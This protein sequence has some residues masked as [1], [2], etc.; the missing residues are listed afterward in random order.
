VSDL[1]AAYLG[2]TTLAELALA[3]RVAE[4]RPGALTAASAAF[5]HFPAPWCPA[6]F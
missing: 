1:G 3:G 5:A 2:G 6:V 4:R